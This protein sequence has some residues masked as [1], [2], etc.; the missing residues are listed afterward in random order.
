MKK[1][2]ILFAVS[3]LPLLAQSQKL[4][5]MKDALRSGASGSGRGEGGGGGGRNNNSFLA[6][7]IFDLTWQPTWWLFYGA[8]SETP[9]NYR[10]F[11]DFPYADEQSG[12]YLP[13]DYEPVKRMSLQLT[14]HLQS[15]QDAVYGAFFQAKWSPNRALNLDV[16]HLQLL[17]VL[18]NVKGSGPSET[19]TDHFTIT[20]FNLSYNRVHHEKF[21]L[22]WGVGLML[23]NGGG[24]EVLYGSPS[25]NVG[26]TWY[27]KKPLSLYA[28]TQIGGPNGVYARQ[29]QVRMQ[30]HLK[31]F[32]VYAGYQGVK[33]G[34]VGL[35]SV[36][37]GSGVW[38]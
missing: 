24:N 29:N 5:G 16:N 35:P 4:E 28:D 18:D 21:Q 25:V 32:M 10:G 14:G 8:P 13:T 27:F 17:E 37:V 15:D 34:D 23:L 31:R 22:W 30:V 26:F 7:L 38:F 2:C 9:A 3:L 36:A 6:E 33:V 20:N 12:L 11:N 19:S 1:I